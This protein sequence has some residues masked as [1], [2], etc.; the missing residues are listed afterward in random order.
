MNR[1]KFLIEKP[2]SVVKAEKKAERN[3]K[4]KKSL[5]EKAKLERKNAKSESK[6]KKTNDQIISDIVRV[7]KESIERDRVRISSR[8]VPRGSYGGCGAR[9]G[10]CGA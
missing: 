8:D 9:S 5:I 3:A 7:A 4:I 6:N 1:N 10:G 2:Q